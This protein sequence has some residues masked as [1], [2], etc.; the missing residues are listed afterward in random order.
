MKFKLNKEI[1]RN[2]YSAAKIICGVN[3]KINI[4]KK[5]LESRIISQKE[6]AHS[7][8]PV[9]RPVTCVCLFQMPWTL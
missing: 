1:N 4:P 8:C 7:F 6:I 2:I 9:F 5:G 3:T